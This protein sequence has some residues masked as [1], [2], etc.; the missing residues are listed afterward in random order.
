MRLLVATGFLCLLWTALAA[1]QSN[2][3]R[4]YDRAIEQALVEFESGHWEE[5]YNLFREA[6]RLK[7]S[8]RTLRGLG[9]VSYELGDYPEAL[10]HLRAALSNE[11]RPLTTKQ[12]QEV[13]TIVQR[14]E[15]LVGTIAIEVTPRDANV[16][17]G[18]TATEARELQVSVG[19]VL[20]R[21]EREGYVAAEQ[22][23]K[24]R[25][26]E[27]H[28]VRL[29]LV[30]LTAKPQAPA[31]ALT[32]KEPPR[33]ARADDGDESIWSSPWLWTGVGAVIAGGVAVAIVVATS[34]ADSSSDFPE[35]NVDVSYEALR[36]REP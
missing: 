35:G 13:E 22:V 32:L 19:N 28:A 12:R 7:P 34:S 9:L 36:A 8:A 30:S 17:V 2:D 11:T 1:A 14:V 33:R 18:K 16:L 24:V 29:Q 6:H 10:V 20:V 15:G 25:G 4:A 27:R 31:A 26:G 3:P 23:V 21:A 5:A